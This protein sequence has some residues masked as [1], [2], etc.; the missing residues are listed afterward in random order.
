MRAWFRVFS[1][2][3]LGVWVAGFMQS[4][5]TEN[6]AQQLSW[7]VFGAPPIILKANGRKEG[8]PFLGGCEGTWA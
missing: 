4:Y 7:E 6:V 5:L 2:L 8:H 1:A 3:G